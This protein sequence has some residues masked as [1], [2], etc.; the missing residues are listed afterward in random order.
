MPEKTMHSHTMRKKRLLQRGGSS[1]SCI[2]IM[3]IAMFIGIAVYIFYLK[4]QG[5]LT[6]GSSV[7][8]VKNTTEAQKKD[9]LKQMK[10]CGSSLKGI[11]QSL[12]EFIA[13]AKSGAYK[14]QADINKKAM[15]VE[16]RLQEV[17]G[18][19]KS[20][21]TP[22]EFGD[23]Q[24]KLMSS[25]PDYFDCIKKLRSLNSVVAGNIDQIDT[26]ITEIEG[27]YSRGNE[28]LSSGIAA[29][30]EKQRSLKLGSIL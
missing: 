22:E 12:G 30:R 7:S 29:L 17:L 23:G 25:I 4:P 18:A 9:Y 26:K 5:F 14:S 13:G 3:V 15:D 28:K 19:L 21:K 10:K 2:A 16:N 6:A 24:K 20:L 11:S 8:T 27:I 1:A